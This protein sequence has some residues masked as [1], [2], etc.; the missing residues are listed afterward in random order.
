MNIAYKVS[1]AIFTLIALLMIATGATYLTAP[2]LMP[3]HLAAM[4]TTWEALPQGMQTMSLNF[5][6]S[7]SAGFL[8]SGFAVLILLVVP[9][10]KGQTWS[11]FA[12]TALIGIQVGIIAVRTYDVSVN[13]MANPPLLPLLMVLVLSVV[14]FVLA[15]LKEK[16]A[17]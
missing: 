4:E 10:R 12:I 14:A 8:S 9:F 2:T 16:R 11:I 13:T 6:K 7:V 17:G 5:M 1:F 15:F 3:Y